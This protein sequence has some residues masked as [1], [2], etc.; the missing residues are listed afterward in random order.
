MSNQIPR[1]KRN[2]NTFKNFQSLDKFVL[3]FNNKKDKLQKQQK[4]RNIKLPFEKIDSNEKFDLYIIQD[5]DKQNFQKL[6]NGKD[7]LISRTNWCVAFKD[8]NHFEKYGT[9]FYLIT[10][11][12]NTAESLVHLK[13]RQIKNSA[14]ETYRRNN[15]K[16][17]Q[18]I[19]K[20]LNKQNINY[21]DL[22]I[23]ED[24]FDCNKFYKYLTEDKKNLLIRNLIQKE[25]FAVLFYWINLKY[26]SKLTLQMEKQIFNNLFFKE[27]YEELLRHCLKNHLSNFLTKYQQNKIINSFIKNNNVDDLFYYIKKGFLRSLNQQQKTQITNNLIKN[28]DY[29]RIDCYTNKPLN[30]LTELTKQQRE[31]LYG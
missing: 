1:K 21:L 31:Q 23:P 6:Y 5:K 16:L 25:W 4:N 17:Y 12:N 11:K 9:P 7:G 2:I 27:R 18:L 14:N 28:K 30:Y 22:D 10:N 29:I 13:S 20:L 24:L 26:L 8:K 15:P 19:I 3:S